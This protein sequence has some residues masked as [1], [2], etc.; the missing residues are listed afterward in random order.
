MIGWRR[1]GCYIIGKWL[2]KE[3]VWVN[4]GFERGGDDICWGRVWD[5][6]CEGIVG[7]K[8]GKVV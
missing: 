4:E 8:G 7:G 1:I 5:G 2:W 3:G 6:G